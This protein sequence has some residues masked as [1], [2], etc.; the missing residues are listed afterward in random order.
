[1]LGI[2]DYKFN[3]NDVDMFIIIIIVYNIIIGHDILSSVTVT[4]TGSAVKLK[5]LIESLLGRSIFCLGY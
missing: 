4:A 3:N 2:A 5:A 1:M